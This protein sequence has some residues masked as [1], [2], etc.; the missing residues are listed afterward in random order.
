MGSKSFTTITS[1]TSY[2]NTPQTVRDNGV[3]LNNSS[4]NTGQNNNS[5]NGSTFI[6]NKLDGGAIGS[7]FG[8]GADIVKGLFQSQKENNKL[9]SEVNSAALNFSTKAQ[10]LVDK[11]VNQVAQK[12]EAITKNL[13]IAAAVAIAFFYFRKS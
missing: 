8:F 6:D 13:M 2:S 11:K 4:L 3:A 9:V 7:A 1:N 5:I 10:E 12:D